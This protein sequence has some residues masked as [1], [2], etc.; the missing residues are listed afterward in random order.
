MIP[1]RVMNV[2]LMHMMCALLLISCATPKLVRLGD[3]HVQTSQWQEAYDAYT[4]ALKADPLNLPLREKT[5]YAKAQVAKQHADQAEKLSQQGKMALAWEEAKQ[6][7]VLDSTQEAHLTLLNNL[8]KKKQAMDFRVMA[9]AAIKKS[10]YTDAVDQLQRALELDPE[11]SGGKAKLEET[12]NKRKGQ[13]DQSDALSLKS[14]KPITL[15]F[16]NTKVKEVFT[17]LEKESGINILFDKEVKDDPVTVFVKEVSF[18]EA[19]HVIMATQGLFMKKISDE[20][21]LIVPKTKSKTDQYQDLLIR[22]F[23]LSHG[24]AKDM[25]NL[26]RTMLETRRIYSNEELNA[27]IIRDTPEKVRLAEKMIHAH[28]L[29]PAEV[30]VN[31]EILEVKQGSG[32]KYGISLSPSSVSGFIA[33][34]TGKPGQVS[35]QDLDKI[36]NATT[37]LVLPSLMFDFF[38]QESEA[39]ILANPRIRVIDNKQAKIKVGD[40]V[41][42][43]LSSTNTTAAT[44]NTTGGSSTTTSIEFK[45]VGIDMTIEPSIHAEGDITMKV[46]ID[47]TSLGDLLEL[48]NGQR[49][50]QFGNRS[51]ETVL[52]IRDGETVVISGLLRDDDRESVIKIPG[53]GDIPYLG[54]LF[55]RTDQGRG[56]T[57]VVM[58]ITPHIL[59]NREI[60]PPSLQ[61]FWSG[62]EEMYGSN[63]VFHDLSVFPP[64]EMMPG[65][66]PLP[67]HMERG[68]PPAPPISREGLSQEGPALLTFFPIDIPLSVGTDAPLQ[69]HIQNA[70]R[71]SSATAMIEYDPNILQISQAIEGDFMQS[72]GAKTLLK[73][74]PVSDGRVQV[75][76]QRLETDRGI[77]GSGL[78]FTLN[79]KG[80]HAGTS[81]IRILGIGLFDLSR[82]PM[83]ANATPAVV[84]VQ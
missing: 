66:M 19:L 51:T 69:V 50:F 1:V 67:P 84:R 6:A 39:Q 58:S 64:G 56:K 4:K 27:V 38:K 61:S 75:E 22:T 3:R 80:L 31:M 76:M 71:L 36:N 33:T 15:N 35:V 41:P 60:P 53:L 79:L 82:H 14:R 16:Q 12:L 63:P 18:I 55:S 5:K 48:G 47:V 37:F 21:I 70:A 25:V 34:H 24:K 57:D 9:E 10:N 81:P 20:T 42:I 45:D 72:D 7:V 77:D 62:T 28:D 73:F 8:M 2:L 74:S 17:V 44:A 59:R 83:D 49:Q 30:M 13:S 40:R 78:L 23:Y 32:A 52:N 68:I 54:R 11:M 26:L 43:L 29:P 65:H 46:K